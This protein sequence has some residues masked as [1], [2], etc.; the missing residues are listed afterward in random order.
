[1][2]LIFVPNIYILRT[3]KEVLLWQISDFTD[4]RGH[5]MALTQLGSRGQSEIFKRLVFER[6]ER[7][8]ST[9]RRYLR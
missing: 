6:I 2:A 1:M 9:I 7:F 3:N 5:V 8:V 4:A